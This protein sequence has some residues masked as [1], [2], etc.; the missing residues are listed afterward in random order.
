MMAT[1][2]S[3][4]QVRQLL[5]LTMIGYMKAGLSEDELCDF[6]VN[7]HAQLVSGLMEKYGV[8]RY[9]IVRGS[10]LILESLHAMALPFPQAKLQSNIVH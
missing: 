10:F 3:Q 6:Q 9:T 5:C 1:T 2:T 8:E 4:P 7:R